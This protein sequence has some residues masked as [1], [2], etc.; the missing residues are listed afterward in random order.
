MADIKLKQVRRR[1]ARTHVVTSELTRRFSYIAIEDLKLKETSST[2]KDKVLGFYEQVKKNA[3]RTSAVL[4]V[5]MCEI[6]AQIDYK[7]EKTS[8]YEQTPWPNPST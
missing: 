1:T 8:T 7:S 4:N 2:A 3:G 6:R 5:S